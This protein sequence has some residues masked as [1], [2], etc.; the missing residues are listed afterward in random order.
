MYDV[1]P[2]H[3]VGT[4]HRRDERPSKNVEIEG[5]EDDLKTTVV[6]VKI[7]VHRKE[8]ETNK[9]KVSPRIFYIS[10]VFTCKFGP[11]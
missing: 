7:K 4:P 9:K 1:P 2:V 5:L 6:N 11:V 3:V 10:L 8:Q